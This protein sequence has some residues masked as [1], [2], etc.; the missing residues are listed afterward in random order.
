MLGIYILMIAL[1]LVGNLLRQRTVISTLLAV[2]FMNYLIASR[3]YSHIQAYRIPI[4]ALPFLVMALDAE[5]KERRQLGG[6]G[7]LRIFKLCMAL[8]CFGI[9]R[10]PSFPLEMILGSIFIFGVIINR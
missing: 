10:N 5:K 8:A 4:Y 9:L 1:I 7:H 2:L 6:Y 3:H